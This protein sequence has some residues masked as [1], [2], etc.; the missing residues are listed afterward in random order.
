MIIPTAALVT[1]LATLMGWNIKTAVPAWWG[2][3]TTEA[4]ISQRKAHWLC[5]KKNICGPEV[6]WA[7]PEA[8]PEAQPAKEPAP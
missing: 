2:W 5:K 8:T 6:K 1:G 7:M 3:Y 4:S